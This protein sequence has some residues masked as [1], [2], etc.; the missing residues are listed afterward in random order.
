VATSRTTG[1]RQCDGVSS[2][3]TQHVIPRTTGS[4]SSDR[5]HLI[6]KTTDSARYKARRHVPTFEPDPHT[7]IHPRKRCAGR[8]LTGSCTTRYLYYRPG[9]GSARRLVAVSTLA[10]HLF[11]IYV[12]HKHYFDVSFRSCH[13]SMCMTTSRLYRYG[14]GISLLTPQRTS[15]LIF[16]IRITATDER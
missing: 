13:L 6:L 12:K 4:S 1:L 5:T 3:R 15:V 14:N 9:I 2:Y 8:C 7:M 10:L 11:N 16:F